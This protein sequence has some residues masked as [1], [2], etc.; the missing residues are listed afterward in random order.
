MAGTAIRPKPGER[1]PIPGG[2]ERPGTQTVRL[3]P[4]LPAVLVSPHDG[5][6]A[7]EATRTVFA[8]MALMADGQG[9]LT[10]SIRELA[11]WTGLPPTSV[12]RSL[13][14]LKE[15]HLVRVVTVGNGDRE[16]VWEIRWKVF[17]QGSVPPLRTPR[18]QAQEER[19][20]SKTDPSP[21]PTWQN[22]QMPTQSE[23]TTQRTL[24][25]VVRDQRRLSLKAGSGSV[26][27]TLAGLR[28][29]LET[30]TG[31]RLQA[32]GIV[33]D[34]PPG[35]VADF[36]MDLRSEI[37]TAF[38]V[39]LWRKFRQGTYLAAWNSAHDDLIATIAAMPESGERLRE[40]AGGERG[41]R[42]LHAFIGYIVE[43]V[44]APRQRQV[45]DELSRLAGEEARL[46]ERITC[47]QD[48]LSDAQAREILARARGQREAA[49]GGEGDPVPAEP[50][51]PTVA[52]PRRVHPPIR[53]PEDLKRRRAELLARLEGGGHGQR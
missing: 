16:S 2:E 14:R 18:V 27:R 29:A 19:T 3:D 22:A 7:P 35:G 1:S 4:R 9:R 42:E 43:E 46:R 52:F 32:A 6:P 50:R 39:A 31:P 23:E 44:F 10:S 47:D 37:Q 8:A 5:D 40:L 15:A 30:W 53:D 48:R 34:H 20:A 49:R 11:R 17:P 12:W 24:R 25:E 45:Q 41:K 13:K 21:S 28:E 26:A 33:P 36:A 38:A 51:P